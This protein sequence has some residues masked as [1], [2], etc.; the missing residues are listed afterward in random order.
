MDV[1]SADNVS[2]PDP[3]VVES[4]QAYSDTVHANFSPSPESNINPALPMGDV[5]FPDQFR[6]SAD[7]RGYRQAHRGY[8]ALFH[9]PAQFWSSDNFTGG[10]VITGRKPTVLFGGMSPYAQR[11]NIP[12]MQT[13]SYGDLV[14]Q[15]TYDRGLDP[16]SGW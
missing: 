3:V 5:Y 15:T 4:R 11:A 9:N 7:M 1:I 13:T 16:N 12:D 10:H 8:V 6:R 14:R 2:Y